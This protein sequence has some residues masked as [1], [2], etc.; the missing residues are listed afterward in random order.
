MKHDSAG[1]ARP[2]Q[3]IPQ[4]KSTRGKTS[5]QFFLLTPGEE[6]S[7]RLSGVKLDRYDTERVGSGSAGDAMRLTSLAPGKVLLPPP[8]SAPQKD[9]KK[10]A[11][12]GTVWCH[13]N[14]SRY[15]PISGIVPGT[16]ATPKRQPSC[17]S[18]NDPG[19]RLHQ[20][21]GAGRTSAQSGAA[22][23]QI[24]TQPGQVGADSRVL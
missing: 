8:A 15:T 6:A 7:C 21:G 5:H 17:T 16:A 19:Q 4:T 22:V 14:L 11:V 1:T 20:R 9:L 10:R 3:K 12:W 23:N 18:V 13:G 2:V 24:R